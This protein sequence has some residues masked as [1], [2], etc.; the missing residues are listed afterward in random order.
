[1]ALTCGVTQGGTSRRHGAAMDR[2]H[3]HRI[4]PAARAR[5]AIRG[6]ASGQEGLMALELAIATPVIIVLLL[7]VVAFGRVTHGRQLVDDAA[8]V[9][10][11]A[12]SL[13][14]TPAQAEQEA[15]AAVVATLTHAG[16]SCQSTD[17]D[18]DTRAFIAGGQV[19][20][21]V[22]CTSRLSNLA[23]TGVPGQVSL[24]ATSHTPLETYRD[25]GEGGAP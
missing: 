9:A 18:V 19:I 1:M 10:G 8:A 4:L 3:W 21:T 12:A 15:R 23:L 14:T 22:H 5:R 24:T 20:V 25:L 11:R 2:N 7:L 6:E 17:V 13:T 16:L